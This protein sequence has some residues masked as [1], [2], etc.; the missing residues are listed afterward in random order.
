MPDRAP[1]AR[2]LLAG[3][4]PL[5]RVRLV[6]AAS[7]RVVDPALEAEVDRVWAEQ[8]AAADA[9]GLRLHDAAAY[10][11][12]TVG[13]HDGRL[14]VGLALEPYRLHSAM[15]V[16]H[17]DPR[18]GPEHHDRTL[19]VDALVR[20]ADGAH[21]LIRTPKVTGLELQLVGGTASPDQQP[22]ASAADLVAFA[23]R[24]VAQALD[25]THGRLE[26]RAVLGAVAHHVGC[27]NL[28]LDVRLDRPAAEV[29]ATGDTELVA[30]PAGRL[31]EHLRAAP[32][33][34]PAVAALL[35]AVD[36]G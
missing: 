24:R 36:R 13:A 7:T 30:V 27:V 14:T 6:E 28:V 10:R 15:K 1:G 25:G 18:V 29:A 11:V 4:W 26:T 3:P 17:A 34:L 5:N 32:G 20:A 12:E 22:L 8:Q 35:E 9:A 33:Y 2:V 19:V 31:D 21:L 23:E 16:L